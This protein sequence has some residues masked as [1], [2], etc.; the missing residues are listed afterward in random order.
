MNYSYP[1]WKYS[2]NDNGMQKRKEHSK[3]TENEVE[4]VEREINEDEE[5]DADAQNEKKGGENEQNDAQIGECAICHII[6]NDIN[7][8][9]GF[10][11]SEQNPC[12]SYL[13]CQHC[14]R[15]FSVRSGH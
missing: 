14:V 15:K 3:M 10:A 9:G 8:S 5:N 12:E 1:G 6:I 4:D 7:F 13:L 2:D 11:D